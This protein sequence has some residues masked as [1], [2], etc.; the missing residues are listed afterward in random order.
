MART[1][2]MRTCGSCDSRC[3]NL[4]I[5][6]C[7]ER[8]LKKVSSPHSSSR[9]VCVSTTSL[10]C[11]T[12][13][14]D[15]RSPRGSLQMS[16]ST[17][18]LEPIKGCSTCQRR[19]I[20]LS[21]WSASSSTSGSPSRSRPMTSCENRPSVPSCDTRRRTTRWALLAIAV[22]ALPPP[23]TSVAT[24][25]ANTRVSIPPVSRIEQSR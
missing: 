2:T 22:L 9:M 12:G 16:R 1:L 6:T 18:E 10:R 23:T 20:S 15:S 8:L 7:S 5:N 13:A 24:K 4:V 14:I 17:P 19:P 21:I 3:L 11:S 25:S